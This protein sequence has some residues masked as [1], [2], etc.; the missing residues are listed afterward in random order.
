MLVQNHWFGRSFEVDLWVQKEPFGEIWIEVKTMPAG[1]F[2]PSRWHGRQ[3]R[4]ALRAAE[5][6]GIAMWLAFVNVKNEVIYIDGISQERVDLK[7]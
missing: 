1:P 7:T 2:A 5:S 6:L 3:R 4:K